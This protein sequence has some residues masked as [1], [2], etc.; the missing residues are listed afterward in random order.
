MIKLYQ[1]ARLFSNRRN[2]L[3]MYLS[4][5]C[6]ACSGGVYLVALPFVIKHLGGMDRHIGIV[7]ACGFGAYLASCLIGAPVMARVNLKRIVQTGSAGSTVVLLIMPTIIIL[8]NR[9]IC[10]VNPIVGV[11]ISSTLTGIF[12]AMFWPPMMGWLSFDHEGPKLNRRLAFFNISWSIGML[13]GPYIGGFLTETSHLLA[14][15]AV[16]ILVAAG[17]LLAS[18]AKKPKIAQQTTTDRPQDES[19]VSNSM[20]K[21]FRLMSRFAMIAV[22]FCIGL[23]RTQLAMLFKHELGFSESQFGTA[24][25]IMWLVSC[26]IFFIVSKTHAW[27][28]KLAP[29]IIPQ[30]LIMI[31]LVI[32]IR[33]TTLEMMFLATALIGTGHASAYM[34]HQFYALSG[35]VIRSNPTV[36]HE[37]LVS[38]GTILGFLVGG[39]TADFFGR[40]LAPYLSG[41]IVVGTAVSI[42]LLIYIY[43]QQKPAPTESI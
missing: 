26:L 30:V 32:I 15:S 24:L 6:M 29:L 40:T 33:S 13:V 41:L 43:P 7:S 9:G 27:H 11:A 16:I 21:K 23:A 18:C 20:R 1:Q 38:S 14:L 35:S 4:T 22:F 12:M 19:T 31:S 10:P 34:S 37:I 2:V 5:F 25:T 36:I 8:Y 28:Y 17:F 42:Q 39:Y 3:W